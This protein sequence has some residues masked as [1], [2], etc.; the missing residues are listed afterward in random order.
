MTMQQ[1]IA[2]LGI[3]RAKYELLNMKRA[4]EIAPFFND[5][6]DNARL[7]AARFVLRRWRAYQAACNAER[8]FLWR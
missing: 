3:N 5:F 6:Q 8:N 2:V 1:A 7:Q 4:L